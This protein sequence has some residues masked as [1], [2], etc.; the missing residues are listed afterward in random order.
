M[1]FQISNSLLGTISNRGVLLS[2]AAAQ[3]E[4]LEI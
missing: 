1:V 4:A 2:H 3:A